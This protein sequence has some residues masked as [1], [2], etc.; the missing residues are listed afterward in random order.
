MGYTVRVRVRFY[1]TA[2]GA[3]PVQRYLEGLQKSDADDVYAALLDIEVH[4]FEGTIL[5]FRPISGKLWELKV[6]SS[7]I[8]YVVVVGPEM[9]L[10]HA[11]TKQSNRAPR[12][13]IEVALRRMKEVTGA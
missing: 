9:V 3:S 13:E 5:H 1:R 8:F 12:G 7:R 11:Y 10:L 6:S 2:S 4:G